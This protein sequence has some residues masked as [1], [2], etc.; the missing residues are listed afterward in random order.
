MHQIKADLICAIIRL[1]QTNLLREKKLAHCSELD[2]DERA[3]VE[4]IKNNAASYREHFMAQ[5]EGYSATELGEIL[6]MLTESQMDL[7]QLLEEV[8]ASLKKKF[9]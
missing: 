1:S 2:H 8:P 4:W 9:L 5:L 6:K 7:D 3:V